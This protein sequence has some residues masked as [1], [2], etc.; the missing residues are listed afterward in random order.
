MK[1]NIFPLLLTIL[2]CGCNN[3][4]PEPSTPEPPE[5]FLVVP[6]IY[7]MCTSSDQSKSLTRDTSLTFS[8]RAEYD[9]IVTVDRSSAFQPID[10][11][12]AAVTGSS[13]YNLMQMAPEDRAAFLKQTFSVEQGYGLNY[14]RISIG[15][16]DFSLSEYTC[17][18]TPGIENFSLTSEEYDYVIPVLKEILAIN[19]DLKIMGS[20]WT[21]PRW[22]KVNNLTDRQPHISWTG[23]QLNPDYYQDYAEY[24]VKWIRAFEAEGVRIHSIT[25]QNEPL[26]RGNSASLY[27]GWEEQRDFIKTAIGPAFQRE[28]IKVKIYA[29]DH[30]FNYDGIQ[31]QKKYPVNIY[32]DPEAASYLAGAAYHDYGGTSDE[33]LAVHEAAPDKELIFTETSIGTWNDGHNLQ[34]KVLGNIRNL[35]I[36]L[37]N[38]WSRGTIV[39]NLMLDS[40]R[41]PK[42]PGG[43]QTCYGAVDIDKSD[44]KTINYN[45]H[46]FMLAHM[47]ASAR[48]GAVRVAN[49]G[50]DSQFVSVG[51]FINEDGTTGLIFN[52]ESYLDIQISIT[53]DSV[54]YINCEVPAR[55][56]MSLRWTDPYY[57]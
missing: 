17:C 4:K 44:Y 14:V 48:A 16:S 34:T 31:S 32:A 10:G 2:C 49:S 38:K 28:G 57:E 23:G 1:A 35:G 46:Y 6:P 55:T 39:W 29:F 37:V 13:A 8:D 3:E 45:S 51:S 42:R 20:P 25:L 27:M 18:D 21:C 53:D 9:K 5:P 54:N 12:G 15:C 56:V 33:L 24:F 52:N 11:F 26:N 19:P 47:S 30:N 40:E 7:R 36:D 50:Y 22:M 43:C 41:G